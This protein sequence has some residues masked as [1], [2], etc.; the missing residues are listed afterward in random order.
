[1]WFIIFKETSWLCHHYWKYILLLYV[2]ARSCFCTRQLNWFVCYLCENIFCV[3][4][5][6]YNYVILIVPSTMTFVAHLVKGKSVFCKTYFWTMH[7]RQF[8]VYV[9]DFF[10]PIVR[11]LSATVLLQSTG[12]GSPFLNQRLSADATIFLISE[13]KR[14]PQLTIEVF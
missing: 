3:A 13:S 1:M 11:P 4:A 8:H 6:V 5:N 2:T 9:F 12:N 10:V 7:T 14:R